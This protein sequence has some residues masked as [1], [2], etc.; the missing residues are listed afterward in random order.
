MTEN[1][2]QKKT[3]NSRGFLATVQPLYGGTEPPLCTRLSRG[4]GLHT[5]TAFCFHAQH[6]TGFSLGPCYDLQLHALRVW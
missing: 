4:L 2:G 3:Q 5:C 6:I 1:K